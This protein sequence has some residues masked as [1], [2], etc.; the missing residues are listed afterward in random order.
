MNGK[1]HSV[2]DNGTIITDANLDETSGKLV[3]GDLVDVGNDFEHLINEYFEDSDGNTYDICP[4][5]H[6]YILKTVMV[7]DNT[8]NGI[9]EEHVCSGDCED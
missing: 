9:H 1:L 3:S 2:W 5:C 8:G 4:N 6:E 7:D